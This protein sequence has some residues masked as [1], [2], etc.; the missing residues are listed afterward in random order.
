M[1]DPLYRSLG[2]EEAVK[3]FTEQ[4]MLRRTGQAGDR[5][6]AA[7]EDRM[8]EGALIAQLL[9]GVTHPIALPLLGA[10]GGAWELSK[11]AG[12]GPQGGITSDPSWENWLAALYGFTQNSPWNPYRE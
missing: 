12:L 11:A 10:A 5:N 7:I 4:D 2:L 6:K 3:R 8:R 9:P 1:A